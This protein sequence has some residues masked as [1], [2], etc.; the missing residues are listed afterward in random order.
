MRYTSPVQKVSSLVIWKIETFT[1]EDRRYRKHCTQDNDTSIPFKAAPWDLTRFSHSPSPASSYFPECH[2]RSEISSL[3]EVILVLG[4]PRSHRAPNLGCRGTESPG[5]LH[6]S[7]KNSEQ[8][9]RHVQTHCCDEAA[10]HQLPIAVAIFIILHL[11]TN[12]EH[13]GRTPY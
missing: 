5:W 3:L 7:P 2:Q 11:S 9:M 12:K 10:S 8:D 1:E 13:W 6:V 4:K